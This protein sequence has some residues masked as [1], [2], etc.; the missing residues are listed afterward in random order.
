M[1]DDFRKRIKRGKKMKEKIKN[2][3]IGIFIISTATCV[4]INFRHQIYSGIISISNAI[5]ILLF[6]A[7]I[8]AMLRISK[9]KE[10]NDTLVSS[11]VKK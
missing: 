1:Q 9:L 11:E 4:F 8:L 6:I 7:L 2:I 3:A 10:L 5:N